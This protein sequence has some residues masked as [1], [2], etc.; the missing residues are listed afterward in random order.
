MTIQL[1]EPWRQ[2]ALCKDTDP[3]IFFP[4]GVGGRRVNGQPRRNQDALEQ[5]VVNNWCRKCPVQAECMEYAINLRNFNGVWGSTEL[6]RRAI[7][8]QR[9]KQKKNAS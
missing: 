9:Q 1:R 5:E 8:R 6:Q 3:D 7:W 4:E 2:E